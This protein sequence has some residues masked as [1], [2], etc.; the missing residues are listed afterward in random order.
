LLAVFQQEATALLHDADL[1]AQH[2]DGLAPFGIV[3]GL[4][5]ET[6]C[7][8]PLTALA[9]VGA[10]A[11]FGL[12]ALLGRLLGALTLG[13]GRPDRAH[14]TAGHGDLLLTVR[15]GGNGPVRRQAAPT[16]I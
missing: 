2:I 5:R 12:T 4:G 11:L 3:R 13:V 16:R 8:C 1:G 6:R 14:R 10:V 15:A 9:V 7:Q